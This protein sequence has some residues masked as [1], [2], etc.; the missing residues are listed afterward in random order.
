MGARRGRALLALGW[1]VAA[2]AAPVAVRVVGRTDLGAREVLAVETAGRGQRLL[3]LAGSDPGR[4][5][6]YRRVLGRGD[7]VYVAFYGAGVLLGVSLL[8]GGMR[9]LG[10][11]VAVGALAADVVEN[12]A[13]DRALGALLADPSRP[14]MSDADAAR[15]RTAAAVKFG[16]LTPAVALSLVG[17]GRG[18]RDDPSKRGR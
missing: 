15:A 16:L 9:M 6:V 4:V 18:L 8:D 10:S 17:V 11:L 2:V 1:L 13:L 5:A 3:D 14:H 7:H 12:E